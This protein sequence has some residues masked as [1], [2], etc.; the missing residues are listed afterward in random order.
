MKPLEMMIP[1]HDE[2][3]PYEK[4]PYYM[5]TKKGWMTNIPTLFGVAQTKM[6]EPPDLASDIDTGFILNGKTFPEWAIIQAHSFF[7]AVWEKHQT[8]SSL[9]ILYDRHTEEFRLWCPE[10]YVTGASVNHQMGTL[11]SGWNA[12]G[13]IHSHCNFG[14]FHSGTDTHDMA[15]M[16]GLHITIGHVDQDK[17]EYAL[18][19]SMND[20]KFDVQY[21]EIIE[22]SIDLPNIDALVKH[23]SHWMGFVK[24]GVAPWQGITMR[25]KIQP[26]SK[27]T[28]K[29]Q[30][31]PSPHN[32]YGIP[33]SI[34]KPGNV[35]NST[36]LQNRWDQDAWGNDENY[37][38]YS[39]YTDYSKYDNTPPEL[40]A[41]SSAYGD[42]EVTTETKEPFN[43]YSEHLK[44]A[45]FDLAT[46][47][48]Y[49]GELG[50]CI[51]WSIY[52]NPQEA[53]QRVIKND[54]YTS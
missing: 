33:T 37:G 15:G 36:Q 13:T 41:I 43:L 42:I 35:N 6:K 2:K 39:E 9:Y 8:E 54:A 11:P 20:S 28:W 53:A 16:P 18:A 48:D 24:Q 34:F 26:T 51:D 40:P 29:N 47:A 21:D 44:D 10:Q 25:Y 5:A 17:P 45:Q 46:M 22:S 32:H 19:L 7:R 12:I 49:L 27:Q 50:F 38:E 31:Q 14:A 3:P 1:R 30:H 23:P 4:V 52:W